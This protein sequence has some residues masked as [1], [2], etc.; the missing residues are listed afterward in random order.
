MNKTKKE[1]HK[2]DFR[3]I[4]IVRTMFLQGAVKNDKAFTEN[5]KQSWNCPRQTNS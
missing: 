4:F 3:G 2:K 5:R 1:L